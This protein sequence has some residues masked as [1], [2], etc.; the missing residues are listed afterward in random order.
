MHFEKAKHKMSIAFVANAATPTQH[1]SRPPSKTEDNFISISGCIA[2][3]VVY[4][5]SF[6]TTSAPITGRCC[7]CS[8]RCRRIRR[9]T[10]F[11]WGPTAEIKIGTPLAN[12]ARMLV[13]IV[14]GPNNN[15][16]TER[17][18]TRVSEE[19]TRVLLLL[20]LLG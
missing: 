10:D 17:G 9:R 1:P 5:R 19:A 6:T 13:C 15:D 7:C 11:H 14:E 20:L 4:C 12:L 2:V 8:R 3:P 16:T 18:G